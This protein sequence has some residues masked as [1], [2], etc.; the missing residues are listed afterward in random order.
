MLPR[1]SSTIFGLVIF[2]AS[3]DAR[4]VHANIAALTTSNLSLLILSNSGNITD[5][6]RRCINIDNCRTLNDIAQSCL[7]T[8]LA[9]A[10]SAVHRNVP[11]PK[12]KRSRHPNFFIRCA[13]WCWHTVLD[14][15]DAG[16]VFFV[17]LLAPEWI[18]AWALRQAFVAHDLAGM[19]EEA[20]LKALDMRECQ[21]E[22]DSDS[23]SEDPEDPEDIAA[24]TVEEHIQL[25]KRRSSA[26][27]EYVHRR[28]QCNRYYGQQC[29]QCDGVAA[30]KRVAKG[31]ECT[32]VAAH[33]DLFLVSDIERSLGY[34]TR[35][36]Y[37][38][39]WI[40][41]LRQRRATISSIT[42]GCS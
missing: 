20:R 19:L 15:R 31:N 35:F 34:V 12:P 37:R 2:L 13:K 33:I 10:W 9:C 1:L 42:R 27:T 32:S 40:P 38:H 22:R 36:F 8:I 17:A 16:I 39:G 21:Q 41:L 14:Q 23:D 28:R 4:A 30:K 18:L 26:S 3:I 7:V 5:S 6:S 29:N 24:F 11:A 25:I